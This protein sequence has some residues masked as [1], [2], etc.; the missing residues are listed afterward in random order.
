MT[1]VSCI[2]VVLFP[3][4]STTLRLYLV[5]LSLKRDTRYNKSKGVKQTGCIWAF[6]TYNPSKSQ[7]QRFRLLSSTDPKGFLRH[8]SPHQA[9]RH[10]IPM[11]WLANETFRVSHLPWYQARIYHSPRQVQTLKVYFVIDRHVWQA[12]L[13]SQ[14]TGWQEKPLV[15]HLPWY[16]ARIYHSP[17]QVQTLKVCFV[18]DR[19]VWQ[20]DL[21]S[22]STGWREK[23]LG[24]PLPINQG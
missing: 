21:A 4:F 14:S 8:Q 13:A 3:L 22:Q 20:A 16:Q 17:R 19:Q 5:S 10:G 12:D 9:R 2:P 1:V 11:F 7:T 23:P 24:S 18:I 15:S 6:L